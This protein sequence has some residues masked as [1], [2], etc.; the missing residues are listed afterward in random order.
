MAPRTLGD[1]LDS[2]LHLTAAKRAVMQRTLA[3]KIEPVD[4][5]GQGREGDYERLG[6]SIA[7]VKLP[8]GAMAARFSTALPS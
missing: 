8:I 5:I 4:G 7:N 3:G 1:R 2:H 6:F